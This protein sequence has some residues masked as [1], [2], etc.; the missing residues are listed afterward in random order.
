MA[1]DSDQSVNARSSLAA[2]FLPQLDRETRSDLVGRIKAGARADADYFMMMG[3]AAILASLGLLQGSGAVVIGAM[4]VAPLMAPLLAAGLALVQ[5]NPHLM[6]RGISVALY[7]IGVAFIISIVVGLINPGYEPSM[8]IE[9]RGKP[10]L[11]DL[12]IAFASGMAGAYAS[13][14][15]KVAATLAGV[16]IA[17]A[18]V[19]PLTVIGIA[20]TNG[21]P[22]I[23]AN[24]AVLLLTNLVCIVLGAALIFQ[25]LGVRATADARPLWVRRAL[26]GLGLTVLVLIAPL[27]L[28]VQ[29]VQR[30]GQ[31]RPFTYPVGTDVR[32]AV[33]VFL[34]D[35]PEVEMIALARNGVQPTAPITAILSTEDGLP[36]GFEIQLRDVIQGAHRGMPVVR[37]FA[38]DNA[39]AAERAGELPEDL[40]EEIE[41]ELD[42]A[43]IQ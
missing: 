6:R 43:Q 22:I 32:D 21:R 17:A 12:G 40:R 3:I 8:E 31:A 1:N 41:D 15:P 20:V 2:R 14:R 18:L 16:A 4:L 7:G 34:R 19:P 29:A 38:L 9:A 30:V 39:I 28:N 13:S 23:A 33:D 26:M 24:A 5:G 27:T 36:R 10:D 42:Q 11:L 35:W 25:L 37:V